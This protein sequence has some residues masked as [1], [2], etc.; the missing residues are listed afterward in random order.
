M[1][2]KCRKWRVFANLLVKYPF[3]D[4]RDL[5]AH[6]VKS[7]GRNFYLQKPL[8]VDTP[9]GK[10]PFP[11]LGIWHILPASVSKAL[12]NQ[13]Y[14]QIEF[15]KILNEGSEAIVLYFHGN[16]FDR[17]GAHRCSLY[18]FLTSMDFHVFSLDYRGFFSLPFYV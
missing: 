10:G 16:S 1:S 11:K 2:I 15:E 4:Y 3:T 12:E 8:F 6:G 14:D 17:T 9:K 5:S 18:N 13:A 7:L